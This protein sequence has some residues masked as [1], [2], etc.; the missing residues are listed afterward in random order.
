[1]AVPATTGQLRE[2]VED[3]VIGDYIVWKYDSTITGY[4]F[5]GSTSAYTEIA[6][7]GHPLANMPSKY[8][9]YAIKVDKGLLISDR[10][11]SNTVSWDKLNSLKLIQG[12]SITISGNYGKLRSLTGAI[13]YTDVNGNP[14]LTN[15]GS[16]FFPENSEWDKYIIGFLDEKIQV[17]KTLNEVFHHKENAV[18]WC[19]DVPIIGINHPIPGG[20]PNPSTNVARV[21]RGIITYSGSTADF[22]FATSS[23]DLVW[24]GITQGF[25]PVFEYKEV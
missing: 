2:R 15:N 19:Q 22:N 13:S 24:N 20:A 7:T 17:G 14:R 3:M 16:G 10:V 5:G 12:I 25:R 21:H 8:F 23:W 18:T 11:V 6:V 9:W 1:M 4:I